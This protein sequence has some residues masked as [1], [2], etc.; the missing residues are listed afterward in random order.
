[1]EKLPFTT[2]KLTPRKKPKVSMMTKRLMAKRH[3][4]IRA[5]IAESIRKNAQT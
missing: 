1:M 4:E 3:Q 2:T 5:E